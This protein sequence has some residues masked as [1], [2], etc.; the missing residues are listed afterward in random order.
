MSFATTI[1]VVTIT[2]S[3]DLA[4]TIRTVAD[5]HETPLAI[6]HETIGYLLG[7]THGEEWRYIDA[8]YGFFDANGGDNWE[9]ILDVVRSAHPDCDGPDDAWCE[10]SFRR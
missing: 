4:T 3:G 5:A 8:P 7:R 9:R 6:G 10:P 1:A 2:A